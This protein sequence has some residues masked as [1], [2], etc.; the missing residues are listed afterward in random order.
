MS[1]MSVYERVARLEEITKS[2]K[3]AQEAADRRTDR[4]VDAVDVLVHQ[5]QDLLVEVGHWKGKFGG[6]VLTISCLAALGALILSYLGNV[7]WKG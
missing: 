7:L 5:L 6:V 2:L 1:E 4:L 3:E